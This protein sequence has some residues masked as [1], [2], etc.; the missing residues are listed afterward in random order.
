MTL[1]FLTFFFFIYF[2]IIGTKL[3]TH[4]FLTLLTGQ[5]VIILVLICALVHWVRKRSRQKSD[6]SSVDKLNSNKSDE[7]IYHHCKYILSREL[8]KIIIIF[9]VRSLKKN[10]KSSFSEVSLQRKSNYSTNKNRCKKI[11]RAA[12]KPEQINGANTERGKTS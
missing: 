2:F 9:D 11:K 5:A 4:L 12:P 10:P 6:H 1:I 7:E 3:Q 8:V